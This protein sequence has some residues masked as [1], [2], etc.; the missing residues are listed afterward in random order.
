MS[1]TGLVTNL[2]QLCP[3]FGGENRG[4]RRRRKK[5][6]GEERRM[7][8]GIDFGDTRLW[9]RLKFRIDTGEEDTV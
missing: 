6:D 7:E 4:R 3:G 8:K 5:G 1:R 9:E 2:A